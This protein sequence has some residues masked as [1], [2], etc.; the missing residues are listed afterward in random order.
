M[1]S[2]LAETLCLDYDVAVYDT[3]PER[4]KYLYNTHRF[5]NP[6]DATGFAPDLM[7]NASGLKQTEVAF[8]EVIPF[9]PSGCII[10]DI[11]SVKNGL[12]E[13]YRKSGMRF[14]STHPMFG[15]TFGNIRELA[16]QNAIIISESDE[17]GKAFFREFYNR[18]RLQLFE[19]S[20]NEHDQ[21]IAYSLS[22]PFSSTIVFSACMK[23]LEVPGTTFRKHLEIASGLLSEDDWLLSGI[24][25]NPYSL[26]KLT[27]ISE[28]LKQL[29][30]MLEREDEEGLH[31]LFA[32]LRHNIGIELPGN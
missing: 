14:V 13:F 20:F 3:D 31:E 10:S 21:V 25:L 9:L 28:R 1:G 7:I 24:L 8:R 4:L 5:R 23:K 2:W 19:Y 22:V 32:R 6:E 27:E 26:G 30:A 29:I 12:S 11:T 16:G 17:E 18:L 15:P